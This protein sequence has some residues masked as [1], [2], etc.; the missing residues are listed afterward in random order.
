MYIRKRNGQSLTELFAGLMV[1]I[2]VILFCVDVGTLF[3]GVSV[4][5]TACRDAARAASTGKPGVMTSGTHTLNSGTQPYDRALAV[6]KKGFSTGG[7]V[8]LSD[9]I[10][11]TETLR[12]PI[13]TAPFGGPV[14]GE[15]T[16]LSKIT[17]APPFLISAVVGKEGVTFQTSQT[18]PY[19]YQLPNTTT[20]ES[21]PDEPRGVPDA[22]G[23]PTNMPPPGGPDEMP[24]TMPNDPGDPNISDPQIP[25]DQGNVPTR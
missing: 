25:P 15:V 7:A 6:L 8:R 20:G 13:P 14:D 12:S 3:L 11:V 17:V 5:S 24:R 16:V 9:N 1:I 21:G 18:F 22:Q 2:P 10:T 19:T 23:S 4:N